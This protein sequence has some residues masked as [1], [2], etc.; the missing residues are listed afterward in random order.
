MVSTLS[1]GNGLSVKCHQK[2]TIDNDNNDQTSLHF[3]S[4][5]IQADWQLQQI[6]GIHRL[7]L[8]TV[9]TPFSLL[10]S[11]N[12]SLCPPDTGIQM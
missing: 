4:T 7:V 3:S 2:K 9:R 11:F 5:L 12:S 6:Q 10:F 1:I 8:W